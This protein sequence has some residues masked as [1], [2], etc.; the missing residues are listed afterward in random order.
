M[1]QK[2]TG[3]DTI[4]TLLLACDV[5]TQYYQ[6]SRFVRK[7]LYI[8]QDQLNLNCFPEELSSVDAVIMAESVADASILPFHKK[9]LVL[10][11]S[12]RRHFASELEKDGYDV[13]LSQTEKT[14][15][16]FL[17]EYLESHRDASIVIMEPAEW[18]PR[19]E[20][21]KLA[22]AFGERIRIIPNT[23]FLA[24]AGSW[25]D[26]VRNGYRMEFF[27]REIRRQTGYLMD[28]GKPEGGEWNYDDRNRKSLPDDENVPE[29]P[30]FTPDKITQEVMADVNRLFPDHFG[31][32]EGFAYAVTRKDALQVFRNFLDVRL[33]N[34]GPYQDAM[35]DGEPFLFHSLIS[36]YLNIGLL[37]AREVCEAAIEAYDASKKQK[38]DSGKKGGGSDGNDEGDDSK[39][40]PLNSVEGFL[41][42][43]IG[44]REYI[45]IYYEAMMP[46]V[47]EANHFSYG[48]ELP[49]LYWSADTDMN[50]LSQATQSVLDHGYAHHIQRLMIL[51]NFSNLTGSDP[52]RLLDWFWFAFVDAHEWVV[53]PNVLGM[54]TF[55][56]GGVLASKP[57]VAGGNYINKM[58]NHCKSCRYNVKARTGESACPFNYLYW[59][60]V[61]R[62]HDKLKQN[63]RI[64]FMIR[65]WDK[66]GEE[67]KQN[68]REQSEVFL[69]ELKRY[70]S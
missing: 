32:T 4:R 57:Y 10:E 39:T 41:R 40:L 17:R 54:S 36:P 34:F 14:S 6:S 27:Y 38:T 13:I 29:S 47:R 20:M 15:A 56:D 22:D 52:R 60:F 3:N 21:M 70:N 44:W 64:G 48:E 61:D 26:T 59:N 69:A 19:M 28:D 68:I 49:D 46:D 1:F 31:S 33:E 23:F 12:A 55:A 7:L 8:H 16:G 53:L 66:K 35:A 65:T 58:S 42:Q 18:T 25:T 63:P 50:C 30:S 11:W 43:I 24:D 2:S 62:E 45:R 67:E 9:K 51:S 37:T 5:R